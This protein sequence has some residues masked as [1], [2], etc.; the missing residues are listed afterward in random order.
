MRGCRKTGCPCTFA[1]PACPKLRG[2]RSRIGP[3]CP[4]MRGCRKILS[5]IAGL[6]KNPE[7]SAFDN[8][9]FW[10]T[11]GRFP[12]TAGLVFDNPAFC[13][14]M[15]GLLTALAPPAIS[16]PASGA[17]AWGLLTAP[18]ATAISKPAFR[19]PMRGLLTAL[20][21][22]GAVWWPRAGAIITGEQGREPAPRDDFAGEATFGFE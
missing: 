15:R 1:R 12:C 17:P 10:D 11:G 18:S 13:S 8:P 5:Q 7:R 16:K 3:A 9:A 4:E 22:P 14:V 19:P 20:A 21:S 6:S 2:C